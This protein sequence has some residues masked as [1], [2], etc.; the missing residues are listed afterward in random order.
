MDTHRSTFH[1]FVV[2]LVIH[3]L[4]VLAT[5]NMEF[6]NPED[7]GLARA[8]EDPNE[9]ILLP[10][11]ELA[12]TQAPPAE[13]PDKPRTYTDIPER[14]A[15]AEPPERPDFLAL[16]NSRAADQL[17]DGEES[18]QPAA[19]IPLNF[20]QVAIQREE[21]ENLPGIQ[22]TEPA[23]PERTRSAAAAGYRAEPAP[24]AAGETGDL[25]LAE[26]LPGTEN[27]P[28]DP[29]DTRFDPSDLELPS[30]EPRPGEVNGAEEPAD[31]TED[32]SEETTEAAE[33]S[34]ENSP[35]LDTPAPSILRSREQIGG[36]RGF[37]FDQI[38]VGDIEGNIV[39]SGEYHLNTL[40]WNFAPWMKQFGQEIQRHWIPPYAYY[41]LG[42]LSGRTTLVVEINPDGTLGPL[43]IKE[44]V[45]HESLHQASVAAIR[46]S[47]PFAP[48][49]PD[50]P[51]EKLVIRYTLEYPAWEKLI[52]QQRAAGG[53]GSRT[54]SRR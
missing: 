12:A 24:E 30:G 31:I 54:G 34:P 35:F 51:E 48:L 19:E 42:I 3:A 49:P 44:T 36:D 16:H 13:D 25:P 50:F 2:S 33:E 1:A 17:P 32:E 5:W 43:E 15:S 46:A 4:I 26:Q 6:V 40:E 10:D 38:A 41:A 39:R 14:M 37:E 20:P 9:L 27:E 47:A 45:G 7:W 18:S 52:R 22:F 29:S 11:I 28:T 53:G 8:E 23:T 21:L